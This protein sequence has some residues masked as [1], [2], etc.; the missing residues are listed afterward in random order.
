MSVFYL[1]YYEGIQ[2][3]NTGKEYVEIGCIIFGK[4][5]WKVKSGTG[6]FVKLYLR[7]YAAD[8]SLICNM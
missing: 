3:A 8:R 2:I 5:A 7:P 1:F 6:N 4:K